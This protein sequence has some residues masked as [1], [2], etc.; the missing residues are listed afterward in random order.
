MSERMRALLSR[1]AEEQ[2]LEQRQVSSV[3]G[4]LRTLVEDVDERLATSE[5]VERVAAEVRALSERVETRLDAAEARSA[6]LA[7]RIGGATALLGEAAQDIAGAVAAQVAE[8]VEAQLREVLDVVGDTVGSSERRLATHVD[9]AVLALAEVV[10]RRRRPVAPSAP[11]TPGIEPTVEHRTDGSPPVQDL[12][13]GPPLETPLDDLPDAADGQAPSGAP[14]SSAD[15]DAARSVEPAGAVDHAEDERADDP[16]RPADPPSDDVV[17]V[18]AD[19][20]EPGAAP[21]GP[22][23]HERRTADRRTTGRS[24]G[25][26][27][28]RRP[29]WR[30]V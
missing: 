20:G 22:L 3:L 1:A 24:D 10:L 25:S 28:R 23:Q 8:R 15:G 9:D 7:E 30:P 14:A 16:E 2:L 21:A 4:E 13:D 17:L 12:A 18:P 29:W 27:R 11:P 19:V 26:G 6:E 5:Q